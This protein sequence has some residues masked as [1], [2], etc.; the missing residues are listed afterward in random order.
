MQ[1]QTKGRRAGPGTLR[2]TSGGRSPSCGSSGAEQRALAR[3]LRPQPW[4]LLGEG[5]G[6]FEG[7]PAVTAVLYVWRAVQDNTQTSARTGQ[8]RG[9]SFAQR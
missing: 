1:R 3:D 2:C 4:C 9:S 7:V 8:A 5:C 6:Q